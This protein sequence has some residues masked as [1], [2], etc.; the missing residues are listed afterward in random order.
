[1]EE[2]FKD[3]TGYEGLYQVSN[4]GNVKSL[5]RK[6]IKKGIYISKEKILKQSVLTSGYYV[7]NLTKNKKQK[8]FTIHQL[9]A[10]A[11]L[12][13]TPEKYDFIV[14]HI[15]NNKLDN[16]VEN[17]QVI[18]QRENTSKDRRNKT[19]NY[20]GV[21]WYKPSNK[22]RANIY[23]NGKS[24]HLGRFDSEY[25]AHLKYQEALQNIK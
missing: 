22:W 24:I 25:E 6:M 3:I 4:L 1:M 11:F 2:I 7:V 12:N 10:I 8:V 15:N 23:I 9:V 21:Y 14:D 18:T 13:H 19:S 5:P 20:T 17:L 16:R